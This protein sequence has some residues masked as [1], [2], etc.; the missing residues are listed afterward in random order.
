MA[1]KKSIALLLLLLVAAV[2]AVQAQRAQASPRVTAVS[3]NQNVKVAYGQ[4]AR[5]GRTLFG[6]NGLEKYGQVWRTGANEATEIT[7][8]KD[9]TFGGKAVKAGTYTLFTIPEA[10]EWTVILNSQLGQFGA[11]EYGRTK[12]KNVAEVKARVKMGK[13]S[14]EKFTITPTNT[15]L[16]MTWGETSV[17]VPVK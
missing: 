7:F 1:M 8:A 9:V 12:E 10:A 15:D 3:P 16:T 14:V 4:P 13:T 17:T 5:K 11:F 6:A 2:P